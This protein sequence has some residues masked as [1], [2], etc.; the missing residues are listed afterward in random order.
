[1]NN[2]ETGRRIRARRIDL[3]MTQGD[4]ALKVGVAISTIQRY[5]AGTINAIKL[6]VIEA[7]ARALYVN[8]EWLICKTDHMIEET[9][10]I[11]SSKTEREIDDSDLMFALWGDNKDVD[12]SDLA[13][14]KRYAAFVRE[15][16]K[17]QKK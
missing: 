10:E 7:I 6:P 1:M 17:E 5:E 8:P 15:R 3:N 9:E 14:V 2:K 16:K 13:D 11:T 4:V 12:E